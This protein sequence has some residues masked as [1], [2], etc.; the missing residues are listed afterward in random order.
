MGKSAMEKIKSFRDLRIWNIGMDLV[1]DIYTV[2]KSF[3]KEELF[4]LTSQM[5]RCAVSIPSNIAEGFVRFHKKEYK[6][7][8]SIAWGSCAEL[9]TQIEI[10]SRL[11]YLDIQ[12]T[13]ALIKKVVYIARM[14]AVLNRKLT[15]R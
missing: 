6:N 5:R 3:P 15:E 14:I 9:E 11:K 13:E 2:T 7:F 12:K 8:L 4:G 10:A 1:E